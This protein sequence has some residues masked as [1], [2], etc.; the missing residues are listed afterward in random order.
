M[1]QKHVYILLISAFVSITLFE[2]LIILY[3]LY[4]AY[5][6]LKGRRLGGMLIK[7]LLLHSASVLVSTILYVPQASGKAIERGLFLL[8][9]GLGGYVER[10]RELLLNVNR[11]LI[12]AGSLLIPVVLYRFY[13]TGQPAPLWGGW[14]EVGVLYSIFSLAAVA[15][16]L[17]FRRF[18]YFVLFMIFTAFVFL[19]M[20][21]SGMMGYGL[22]LLLLLWLL[23]DRVSRKVLLGVA[24]V[25]IAGGVGSSFI[26]SKKDVR[27]KTVFEVI[28]GER[29]IN[30]ETLNIISSTR[31]DIAKA[32]IEVIKR[33]LR[34]GNYLPLLIGHGID[35]GYY[36]EP[37]SP[38]GGSYES[39]FLLS[40]FIEK[41]ALGLLG[42]LWVMVAY[43]AYV[44]RV[45]LQDFLEIPL[46]LAPSVL[47]IGSVFTFFWDALLPL[48]LFLFRILEKR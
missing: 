14:F 15:M 35:S 30:D 47:F 32:G 6:L 29:E 7:P 12:A 23:R 38:V 39:V 44:L 42:V 9:Y 2:A 40:E 25:L 27:F 41:G 13:K 48:Y 26:L 37:R 21:R 33:D 18:R 31:W 28:T 46:L 24:L 8:L 45:G 17:E 11:L 1:N 3:L 20:R 5:I 19:S 22:T 34:E 43:Y 36:L 16:F 4:Y 10:R